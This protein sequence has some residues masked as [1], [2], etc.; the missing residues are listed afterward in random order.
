MGQLK[1]AD[2]TKLAN[3]MDKTEKFYLDKANDKYILYYPLFSD[4][5]ID[6]LL[7]ELD[8]TIN[9][10]K[11]ND[12]RL[13][14][15]EKCTKYLQFL[16]VKHFTSLKDELI[17]RSVDVH[18]ETKSA[19]EKSGLQRILLD[20]VLDSNEIHKVLDRRN[21]LVNMVENLA[22]ELEKELKNKD[23][24]IINTLGK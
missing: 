10:C 1:L 8:E 3:E 11:E 15:D 13:D 23:L 24:K 19:L 7:Q 12:K 14:N 6:E 17:D 16:I 2:I 21:A 4:I 20:H 18:F 22:H 9:H 5:K